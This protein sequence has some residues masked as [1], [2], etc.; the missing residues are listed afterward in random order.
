[1][2][3][4]SENIVKH[5]LVAFKPIS[6][7]IL[8]IIFI[9]KQTQYINRVMVIAKT[10]PSPNYNQKLDRFYYD[11]NLFIHPAKHER[12]RIRFEDNFYFDDPND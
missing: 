10:N 1:M 7:K 5:P 12:I 3:E 8:R 11:I 2:R 4:K 6:W 9:Q